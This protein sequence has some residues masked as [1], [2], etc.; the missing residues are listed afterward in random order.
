M[1]EDYF[2]VHLVALMLIPSRQIPQ[3]VLTK[4]I[5]RAL[6]RFFSKGGSA[7]SFFFWRNQQKRK[8]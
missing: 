5:S 8:F 4:K 3:K 2:P 6:T 7:D 1:F